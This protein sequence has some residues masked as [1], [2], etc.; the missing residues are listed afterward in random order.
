MLV[1]TNRLAT[2]IIGLAGCLVVVCGWHLPFPLVAPARW[3]SR[4]I[5][6]YCSLL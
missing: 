5:W 2:M 4:T 3:L 6:L 1:V